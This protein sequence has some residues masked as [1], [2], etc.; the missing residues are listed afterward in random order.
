M[1]DR[2]YDVSL[3]AFPSDS[4]SIF[5]IFAPNALQLKIRHGRS[6]LRLSETIVAEEIDEGL[7]EGTAQLDLRGHFYSIAIEPKCKFGIGEEE[8]SHILDPYGL[9]CYDSTATAI[10]VDR[11]SLP[12]A[13]PRG[14]PSLCDL[15]I[16]EGHLRDLLG[17][18][19]STGATY[20]NF[21]R[22]LNSDGNYLSSLGANAIELQ[23]LQEFDGEDGAYHWGYMPVN[24]F[25]PTRNYA[26]DR[27]H[28][29]QIFEFAE[30]VRQCHGRSMSLIMDVVYN[31]VGYPNGLRM[32]GGDYFFR[33][34]GGGSLSNCS[35][36]GN[37]LRTEAPM[38]RKLILDSLEHMLTV[39][40]VDGFRFDLA[41]LIDVETR[42][43]IEERIRRLKPNAILIAEP[44]SFR[45]HCAMDLRETSWS[46]WNDDFRDSIRRYVLGE[47]SGEALRYFIGGCTS[48]LARIPQQSIN[49]GA[50]HDDLCWIDSIAEKGPVG[51]EDPTA[52]DV[53]RTKLFMAILFSC[54]GVPMVAQ[55]QDF[56]HSKGG[57]R[58][59]YLRG[60][61]N[62]LRTERLEKFHAMHRHVAQWIRFRLSDRGR[63]MRLSVAPS[64]TFFSY[65]AAE[66]S[67]AATAILFNGDH[68]EGDG[69]LLLL[70]NPDG[71]AVNFE[72]SNLRGRE[73]FRPIAS[74]E[75]FFTA[76]DQF[77][78]R[79]GQRHAIGAV[80]CEL[81]LS[82]QP[83][84]SCD[85]TCS[86][87]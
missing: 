43:A 60:D 74:G 25:S 35:G 53:A 47:S 83:P 20:G 29:S 8:F 48:H 63:L 14:G 22:W 57:N 19:G 16:V 77:G 27:G 12:R 80:D 62:E 2:C 10:A 58:N 85:S 17:L 86:A 7:W 78:A 39:Y 44:W 38:C 45:G 50:S 42:A 4:A 26:S 11:D 68:S 41:E 72:L 71:A 55:G 18:S 21:C 49:Y 79:L 30:L 9:A 56:L 52:L 84:S 75:K 36:C 46:F 1:G 32:L 64:P 81:W 59:S 28:G 31:H 67:S 87:A 69:N 61:L 37:D 24:Y 76:A 82:D 3:G 73:T 5:R 40:G 51:G 15:V 34:D 70:V 23:P 33:L 6:A 54:L 65:F 13:V 66:N